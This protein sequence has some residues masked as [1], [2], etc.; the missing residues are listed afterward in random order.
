MANSGDD[1][2]KRESTSA[3]REIL[4][5][6][7]RQGGVK[8]SDMRSQRFRFRLDLRPWR[9]VNIPGERAHELARR[10]GV[11]RSRVS[12][13]AAVEGASHRFQALRHAN[14]RVTDLAQRV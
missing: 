12:D 5:L 4:D 9:P 7:R 8:G 14:I 13:V 1:R 2:A 11:E 10:G 3:S 6:D